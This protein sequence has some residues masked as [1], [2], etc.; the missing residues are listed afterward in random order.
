MSLSTSG[1][2][3]STAGEWINL[4]KGKSSEI[5]CEVRIT[6]PPEISVE[7]LIQVELEYRYSID[8]STRVTVVGTEEDNFRF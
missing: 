4:W 8:S 7:K 5:T 3:C 6:E 1:N 2:G